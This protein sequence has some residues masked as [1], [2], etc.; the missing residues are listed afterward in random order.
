MP[1][2]VLLA[3][4][5]RSVTP[6]LYDV[7]MSK[8]HPSGPHKSTSRTRLR[9]VDRGHRRALVDELEP[10]TRALHVEV[11]RVTLAE[12]VPVNPG[13]LAIVLSA[14][15]ERAPQPLLFTANDV[16]ELLWFGVA[17]F[18]E[19]YGLEVPAGCSDALHAVLAIGDATGQL[20]PDSDS[21]RTL[22]NAFREL[23]AN[24]RI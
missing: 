5:I 16:T 4:L 17:E 11:L 21:P 20:H 9:C 13:A 15:D 22:F 14:H 1:A 23:A 6:H 24:A 12:G 10:A 8:F 2:G 18:C 7:A 3:S 19:E